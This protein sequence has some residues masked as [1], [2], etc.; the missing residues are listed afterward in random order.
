MLLGACGTSLLVLMWPM[1]AAT[2]ACASVWVSCVYASQWLTGRKADVVEGELANPG[3]ELEQERERLA[4]TTGGTED[5]DL[6][7]LQL[8]VLAL[9][10]LPIEVFASNK[11]LSNASAL[12]TAIAYLAS[13]RRESAALGLGEGVPGS[14]HDESAGGIEEMELGENCR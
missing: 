13:R 11:K 7:G 4:N 5:G 14:E 1:S 2:P 12:R 8:H 3:V 9:T 6:G 10:G